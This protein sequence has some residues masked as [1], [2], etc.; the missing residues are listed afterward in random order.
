MFK[1][2]L[3][4]EFHSSS[5]SYELRTAKLLEIY[6]HKCNEKQQI[7]GSKFNGNLLHGYSVSF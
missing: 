7:P 1:M 3:S 5:V 4:I 6:T 2:F